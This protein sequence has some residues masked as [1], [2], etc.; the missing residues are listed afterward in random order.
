M[1]EQ[2]YLTYRDLEPEG[3]SRGLWSGLTNWMGAAVSIFLVFGLVTWG[4]RLTMRDVTDV[5]VVR[6]MAGPFRVQPADPGG[7]I[8]A[9]QGLAVNVVQAGGAA[10]Q[11]ADL[12]VLAPPPL[13]LNDQ[14]VTMAQLR[15]LPKNLTDV[16]AQTSS[17]DE[18]TLIENAI[19]TAVR[20]A[21]NAPL[22]AAAVKLAL[23]PGV[24]T[25]PRP[26]PRILVTSL[27]VNGNSIKET[28]Q[29]LS[30]STVDV[31]ASSVVAGTRL[32]QLG[33]FDDQAS[34]I[35]EWDYIVRKNGDLIG[36]RKRLIQKS[37]SGGRSFYR[38]RM[39]GFTDRG[40]SRRFCSALLARGTPCIPVTAR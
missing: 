19:K 38:L 30:A 35:K 4:Y 36:G 8:V 3:T 6:A 14:D 25:S 23:L 22:G 32:V 24:K 20:E 12:V 17:V 11:P 10:A 28:A 37:E 33:A 13:K 31:S 9:H 16:S 7:A 2:T 1:S 34:A 21:S 5:P 15:P 39:V 40:D 29:A 18:N 26:R 27:D